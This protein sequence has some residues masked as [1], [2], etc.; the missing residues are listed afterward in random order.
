MELYESI[1][2]QLMEQD[3]S[4]GEL[5][6]SIDPEEF[7]LAALKAAARKLEQN[8]KERKKPKTITISG[9]THNKIKTYCNSMGL[10]IGKWTE[11][12]LKREIS[13]NNCVE[14]TNYDDYINDTAEDIKNKYTKKT[15]RY[16][17]DTL[18]MCE[19]LR[20]VG[21]SIVDGMPIYELVDS[22][23]NPL[24]AA[25]SMAAMGISVEI[26]DE[27]WRPLAIDKY[28]METILINK[29]TLDK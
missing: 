2:K 29:H 15:T 4:E 11:Q 24:V 28:D 18:I 27:S 1:L 23:I 3:T 21:E 10:N 13:E 7:Q 12:V 16:K 8:I 9:D 26:T 25:K 14:V 22:D 17:T 19:V 20:L 5:D 6:P